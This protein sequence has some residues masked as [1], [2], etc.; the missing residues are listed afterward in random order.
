MMKPGYSEWHK[1]KQPRRGGMI[2][3]KNDSP[4]KAEPRRGDMIIAK[5]IPHQNRTP[6]G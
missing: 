2:I 4:I 5:M 6:K 1:L 3:A